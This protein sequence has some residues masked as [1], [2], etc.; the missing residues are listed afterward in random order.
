MEKALTQETLLKDNELET[1]Y[2]FT[3][4]ESKWAAQAM[5]DFYADLE[6]DEIQPLQRRS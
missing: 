3:L 1:E 5:A 6:K 2:P 4:E